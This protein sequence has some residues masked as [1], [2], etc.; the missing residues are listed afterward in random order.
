RVPV[1]APDQLDHVPAGAAEAALQ[2]LDD[3]AV[4]AHRAVQALQVAVDHEH[5]VVQAL[6]AGHADGAQALGLVRLAVAQ[7]APDLAVRRLD[8]ATALEVL[9]ETRLVDRA[10]R[11][12]A[13]RHR[14]GLP[15]VRHQPRVRV[16]GD[17]L[18]VHFH[19]EVVELAFAD[20]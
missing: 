3:L 1:A 8:Q 14:R 17:A 13:H 4:A 15:V 11:A 16:A 18:A 10:D 2:L 9:Q 6:A 7:E 5:Q 19:A 20:A 12:Q